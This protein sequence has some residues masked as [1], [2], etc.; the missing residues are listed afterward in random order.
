MMF[1]EEQSSSDGFE[2]LD[3]NEYSNSDT[4]KTNSKTLMHIP[5][6]ITVECKEQVLQGVYV[7][8]SLTHELHKQKLDDITGRIVE[9]EKALAS[10]QFTVDNN[11]TGLG[12]KQSK[13]KQLSQKSGKRYPKQKL[14]CRY[15]KAI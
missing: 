9:L 7:L 4:D 12:H 6:C 15:H 3:K 2:I 5:T 14:S 1:L 13:K 10:L 8:D 11:D